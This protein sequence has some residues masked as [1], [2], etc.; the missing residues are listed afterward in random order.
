MGRRERR[1]DGVGVVAVEEIKRTCPGVE[2]YSVGD[3][4]TKLIELVQEAEHVII[5]DAS[6][7]GVE[8]GAIHRYSIKDLGSHASLSSHGLSIREVLEMAEALG[9]LKASV[10]IYAVE[11]RDFGYGEGLSG[12]VRE[13]LDTLLEE[14]RREL[15]C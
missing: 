10:V 8:P 3:D 11:G 15:G 13:A 2:A 14:I 6:R 1:D 5:I 7:R 9:M 12:E 4:L